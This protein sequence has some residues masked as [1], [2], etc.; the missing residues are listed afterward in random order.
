M[1][2]HNPN[3]PQ[4]V[5]IDTDPGV[6]D[7]IAI[8]MALA[9]PGFRVLGLTATAGNVPLARAARNALALLEYAGRG[10]IPTHKGAARP[11]RGRYPY[12]RHI[13]SPSG[14]TAPLPEPTLTASATPA[15]PFLAQTLTA[16]PGAV[17]VIALGPLTNLARLLL[18]HPDALRSAARIIVM[19]GAVDTPGNATPHAEF[20]FYSDPAAARLVIASGIPLT[21]IDLAACRQVYL[22]RSG[23]DNIKSAGRKSAGRLGELAARLLAGWFAKDPARRQ[24]H[25]YDPLAVIAAVAPDALPLRTVTLEIDD[26]ETTGDASRWG[27]CRV[28]NQNAGPISVAAPDGVNAPAAL[29]AIRR[30]L[31]WPPAKD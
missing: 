27:Q 13:H 28:V 15:V 10:D 14:L 7:A 31:E 6:D 30:L 20:N 21:L 1:P 3:L 2:G 19:G 29:A 9:D 25:L 26:P 24:F 18:D 23:L 12:A 4:P 5:I 8:L 17:T 16:M 11:L 22:P